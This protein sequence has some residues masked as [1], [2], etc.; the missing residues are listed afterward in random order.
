MF[1]VPIITLFIFLT[2]IP[3][4]ISFAFKSVDS[5]FS[6]SEECVRSNV[7]SDVILELVLTSTSE[8]VGVGKSRMHG[9]KL[10][11]TKVVN[12][13]GGG[14]VLSTDITG[15]VTLL[16][17]IGETAGVEKSTICG[18]S[19]HI[20]FLGMDVTLTG[21]EISVEIPRVRFTSEI[22]SVECVAPKT[23]SSKELCRVGAFVSMGVEGVE[24]S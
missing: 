8:G 6:D 10:F 3:F 13:E 22:T 20:I 9:V 18:V 23:L 4:K 17:K 15:V 14:V 11:L 2:L 16:I 7:E 1:N 19:S 24:H 12:S 5:S 21:L